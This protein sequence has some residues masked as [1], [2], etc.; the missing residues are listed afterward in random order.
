MRKLMIKIVLVIMGIASI[1][2]P[3]KVEASNGTSFSVHPVL[4]DNQIDKS[5]AYFDLSMEAKQKQIIEIEIKNNVDEDQIVTISSSAATSNQ[6][7]VIEYTPNKEEKDSSLII[8]F[9]D[10]S[11]FQSEVTI[12]GNSSI[13]FPV[14]IN[15]LDKTFDGV[16][17][18]GLT[19]QEKENSSKTNDNQITNKFAYSIAVMISQ[20]DTVVPPELNLQSIDVT[21][22][23]LR[24]VIKATIQNEKATVLNH[25]ELEAS[26]YQEKQKTPIYHN[27]V[28][29]Y[30]MAPNS[31]LP[32]IISTNDKPLKAG[33]YILK[34]T[35]RSE[36]KTWIWEE[37][38]EIESD[39]AKKLNSTAVSL[40]TDNTMLIILLGTVLILIILILIIILIRTK[41]RKT[42]NK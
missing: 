31:T 20:N 33:K 1:T 9:E 5:K 26:I 38:F 10:I 18:G 11:D 34:M 23:N 36:D 29:D 4:P 39:V 35:A 3:L 14:E 2:V 40:E 41:K 13:R 25:L 8:N 27:Q 17:L 15:M 19:F 7:G 28:T 16:I 37:N 30:R 22:S 12:P 24:N 32:F 42:T 6:N 21:Q